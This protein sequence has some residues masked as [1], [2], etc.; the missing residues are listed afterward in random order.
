MILFYCKILL[1]DEL[2]KSGAKVKEIVAYQ[3]ILESDHKE[4]VISEIQ[5]DKIDVI[6]FTSSSTVRNFIQLIGEEQLK[7]LKKVE[8]FKFEFHDTLNPTI[9]GLFHL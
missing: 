6:T 3:T 7:Q 5:S 9:T 1:K 8:F 2:K 4:R